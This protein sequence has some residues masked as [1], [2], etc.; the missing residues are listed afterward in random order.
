[1]VS[2]LCSR[3]CDAGK[4]AQKQGQYE[5]MVIILAKALFVASSYPHLIASPT[6]S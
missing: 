5:P 1:M 6:P 4:K 2:D 3:S